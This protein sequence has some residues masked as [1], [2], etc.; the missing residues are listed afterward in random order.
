ML[1]LLLCAV[2]VVPQPAVLVDG[3]GADLGKSV[4]GQIGA[5]AVT[6]ADIPSLG[7]ET[8]LLLPECREF[9][10]PG[11]PMIGAFIE[12]GGHLLAVGG[13]AF[14][15]PLYPLGD[16]WK[17]ADEVLGSVQ[18]STNIVDWS[19]IDLKNAVR[20]TRNP[21]AP[22][23]YTPIPGGF[24][25][26]V[27]LVPP[28][29]WETIDIPCKPGSADDNVLRFR[30]A[31][32]D[33]AKSLL[34]ELREKD[35]TRWMTV[36]AIGDEREIGVHRDSFEYWRDSTSQGRGGPGDY[37]R[38][39]N[40]E[41]VI[42][43][44]AASHQPIAEGHYGYSIANVGTGKVE[45]TF[46]PPEIPKLEGFC[47][48]YKTY[49]TTAEIYEN[50][51][52]MRG[53]AL[54]PAGPVVSPVPRPMHLSTT[55]GFTWEPLVRGYNKAGLWVA[56]PL[57]MTWR[58]AGGTYTFCG[59][60]PSVEYL[61]TLARRL[62]L[63]IGAGPWAVE[64]EKLRVPEP[65]GDLVRVDDA[66]GEFTIGGKRWFA[67]GINF[68]PLCVSGLEPQPYFLHWLEPDF[69]V[70]ECIEQDLST[71]ESMGVNMVSIQFNNI[72]QAPALRDFVF[73]C[74]LHGI[75][76]NI[77]LFSAHPIFPKGDDDLMQ[78]DFVEM[79]RAADLAGAPGV[80]AY[81]LAW[82]PIVGKYESRKIYDHLWD[83]WIVEQYGSL[84]RAEKAWGVPAN[85]V[86]GK[87]TAPSD[88]QISKDGDQRVM[89]AAYRRFLDDLISKRY[90][91]VIRIIKSIDDTHLVAARTGYGGTGTNWATESMQFQLTAGS[92]HLDFM[93][94]EGY[95]YGPENITDAAF[96]SQFGRWAGNGKP[97]VW[98][99]FGQHVWMGGDQALVAQGRLYQAFADM[100]LRTGDGGW[101]GWWFPGGY[102]VDE[103][104]DYGIVSPDSSLRPSAQVLR[105]TAPILKAG[106]ALPKGDVINVDIYSSTQGL[107]AAVQRHSKEF[108]DAYRAG[109][110]L[111]IAGRAGNVTSTT[112]PYT[113]V[114]AVPYVAPMPP[115]FLNAEV[116]VSGD[117]LTVINTGEAAWDM[118]DCSLV[119]QTPE[120]EK[121]LGKGNA[122]ARR[123]AFAV[124]E[125]LAPGTKVF[126]R[127]NRFGEFGERV[128]I[129][130]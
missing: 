76:A 85:R 68:W 42:F 82:E 35:G 114:G 11:V 110:R 98:T 32:R 7:P 79:L 59:F 123:V 48:A 30:A 46:A 33:Q 20:G 65:G 49:S 43:G 119:A 3:A 108:G 31:G 28:V 80:V 52:F 23:S 122:K 77:F 75:K 51:P 115:E 126:M 64:Q 26:E 29:G 130:N 12:R 25:G 39:E 47:P 6:L 74:N 22:V 81:D 90:R 40:L 112:C 67:H 2:A 89:V 95:G 9:P 118:G 84:E 94:P 71:L 101:A 24:S 91:E 106:G 57:S 27:E 58:Q 124:T 18:R 120:G 102:R 5:R 53:E 129:G 34:V 116:A 83:A 117:T 66:T 15:V 100:V 62:P 128:T 10:A 107:A 99:E 87:V 69:Y 78:R 63:W 41:K 113:G 21:E 44:F 61:S 121:I 50:G 86:D 109:K 92:A 88:E 1:A 19:A 105:D 14:E 54:P 16:E 104:S 45:G 55:R 8:L 72:S 37:V 111:Q 127:S 56:T 97:V 4:A 17:S 60:K 73:R 93:S 125:K 96:V 70:P 13:P 36:V 103:R 38:F